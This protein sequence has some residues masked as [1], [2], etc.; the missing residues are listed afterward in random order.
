MGWNYL[1]I[2]KLQRLHRWS[3]AMDKSLHP[4]LYNGCNYLS[5]PGLKLNHV[6]KRDHWWFVPAAAFN[7]ILPGKHVLVQTAAGISRW[8]QCGVYQWG[9]VRH[10]VGLLRVDGNKTWADAVPFMCI[11][12]DYV[13]RGRKSGCNAK[14]KF[15]FVVLCYNFNKIRFFY[16]S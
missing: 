2:P 15:H 6:S 7:T 3:L 16:R 4:I 8:P 10:R 1:S 11:S 12:R 5:M 14:R 9:G 13:S